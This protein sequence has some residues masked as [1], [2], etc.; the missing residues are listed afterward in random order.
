MGCLRRPRRDAGAACLLR[1][2]LIDTNVVSEPLRRRPEPRVSEWIDNQPLETLYLSTVTVA[3]L[4]FGVASLPA[5]RRRSLLNENLERRILSRFA[6]RI[7]PF[8]LPAAE[9]YAGLMAQAR[10]DGI[11]ISLSDGY[12]AA[13]ATAN[14]M[15]VAT[16]DRAPFEAAGLRVI[17]PWKDRAARC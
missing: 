10:S 16:R 17:D 1:V 14:G 11:A 5:G 3:E 7:L 12:I 15:A 6:G 13:I 2:I 8:D 4:R 9:A